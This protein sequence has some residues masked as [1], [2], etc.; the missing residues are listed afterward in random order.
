MTVQTEILGDPAELVT[1]VDFRGKVLKSWRTPLRVAPD[2]PQAQSVA[3]TWHDDIEVKVRDSLSRASQTRSKSR[4]KSRRQSGEAVARLFAAG[5]QA[6]SNSDFVT[7][8]SVL[9]VCDELIGG[10]RRIAAALKRIDVLSSPN[11]NTLL[12]DSALTRENNT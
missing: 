12:L 6:Y 3:R 4:A 9:L 10:D 5:I 11:S 2:A 8:K 7:A 1:I